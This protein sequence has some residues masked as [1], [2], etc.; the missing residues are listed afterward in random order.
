MSEHDV[1]PL[2]ARPGGR[3]AWKGVRAELEARGF[4]P[5]QRFGQ[6]FLL[7]DN[8]LRAIVRDADLEPGARVLEVGPGCGFLTLHLLRAGFE[9]VCVE[10]DP[11]L[12]EIATS[13]LAGE[14]P[15]ELVVAD[16][17]DG[18]HALSA[19]VAARLPA[20]EPWHVV[21]NLPYSVGGPLLAVLAGLE[22]PPRSATVLI[23]RE[24]AERLAAAPGT[25]E[26]G[27][28]TLAVQWLWQVDMGR[29]V[30]ADL[31]WPRPNVES[32]VVHLRP[33]TGAAPR[34][35]RLAAAELAR[36][37]L[38][39]RRQTILR[40]LGDVAGGRERAETVL[41]KLGVKPSAR[42][43]E[44]APESW[45]ELARELR[46]ERLPPDRTTG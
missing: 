9:V 43:E 21:A 4:R 35:E 38:G 45:L 19:E 33:R 32:S 2:A 1:D 46:P 44:L 16:V 3:P 20:S 7:D 24:V 41:S 27:P 36:A 42:A 40:V 5:S 17:L 37:L 10:I 6:N 23:Q 15:F 39:R 26:F 34:E 14:R 29:S 31:F 18:K 25:R 8:V 30:G 13:L 28:L 22:N 12:A 11:R